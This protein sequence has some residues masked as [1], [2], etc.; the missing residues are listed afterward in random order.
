MRAP[1]W[2]WWG[3]STGPQRLPVWPLLQALA[4]QGGFADRV[5]L[6]DD[7]DAADAALG[8]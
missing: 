3:A 2:C 7:L 5:F 4:E 1:R 6:V 8:C